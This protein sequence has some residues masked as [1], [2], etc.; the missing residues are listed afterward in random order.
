MRWVRVI[1]C[2][3][4]F[5]AAAAVPLRAEN[6]VRVESD[7]EVLSWDPHA[8]WHLMSINACVQVYEPLV[9]IGPDLTPQPSL[10][11]AVRGR[12]RGP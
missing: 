6:V 10:A 1:A 11:V 3:L 7:D 4:A 12:N 5:T 2:A 9:Y 8:A